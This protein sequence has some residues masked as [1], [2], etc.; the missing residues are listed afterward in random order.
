MRQSVLP[1]L[2]LL[3]DRSQLRLGRSLVTTVRECVESGLTHVVLRELDLPDAQRSALAAALG[4]VGATVIAAH[5]RLPGTIGTHLPAT[6]AGVPFGRSCHARAEVAAAAAE[7]AAY[8]TLGPFGASASKPGYGPSLPLAALDGHPIPVYAL[9]GV[10]TANAADL[11]DAGAY[12]VAVMGSVMRA[13]APSGVVG[14]L[15]AALR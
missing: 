7:G 9:G 15:L 10:T 2:L 14:D 3:T 6:G 1:R 8:A 12:G 5:R 4:E 13:D 11:R